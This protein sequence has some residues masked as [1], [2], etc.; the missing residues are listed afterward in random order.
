MDDCRDRKASLE[1]RNLFVTAVCVFEDAI[2]FELA[3][4][5]RWWF[6]VPVVVDGLEF[7]DRCHKARLTYVEVADVPRKIR[8]KKEG[9]GLNRRGCLRSGTFPSYPSNKEIKMRCRMC[10]VRLDQ[11]SRGDAN[12]DRAGNL[13]GG[14]KGRT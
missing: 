8:R 7:E 11:P 10:K 12:S 3:R 9:F 13:S 1:T 4:R 14:E 2:S 6:V 5:C